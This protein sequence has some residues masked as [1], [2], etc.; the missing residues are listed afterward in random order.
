MQCSAVCV[1]VCACVWHTLRKAGTN[2]HL[3]FTVLMGLAGSSSKRHAGRPARSAS[4]EVSMGSAS[5]AAIAPGSGRGEDR[6]R[7]TREG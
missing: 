5:S 4:V 3:S 6:E 1:C 7:G 2:F